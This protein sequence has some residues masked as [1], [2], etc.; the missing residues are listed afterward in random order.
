MICRGEVDP[1]N[2]ANEMAKIRYA[3]SHLRASDI[4]LLT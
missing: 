3:F 4:V 2:E 1:L